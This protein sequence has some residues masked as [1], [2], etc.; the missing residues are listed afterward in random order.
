MARKKRNYKVTS[1]LR[2][3]LMSMRVDRELRNHNIPHTTQS[4][5]QVSA[6]TFHKAISAGKSAN[7]KGWM[8]DVHSVSEYRSMRCYLTADGK[9]G[10]A[11][12]RNGDV[13]SL[14][15]AGG[16]GK[17]GKLLPFA[18]AAGGRKLDCFGGGLQNMYAAYG[19]RA[20][21]RTPFSEENAPDDWNREDGK[22]DVVAMILP[23]SLDEVVKAY[24]KSRIIDLSK[25][26]VF[27]GKDGYTNMLAD[28]DRRLEQ[29]RGAAN[30]LGLV[31]G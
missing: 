19:A 13:V 10:I 9:S 2:T 29:A 5:S 6:T 11:I 4:I 12:K 18:V 31:G 16:G 25:V 30:G 17:L 23:S 3:R 7:K 1:Q 28:R 14:F 27:N 15:S 8:V 20:T 22:P 24:D 26:R 21:G